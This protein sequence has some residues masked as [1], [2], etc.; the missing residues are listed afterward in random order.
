MD[1]KKSLLLLALFMC[2]FC[3]LTVAMIIGPAGTI[4]LSHASVKSSSNVGPKIKHFIRTPLNRTLEPCKK[5]PNNLKFVNSLEE[6]RGNISTVFNLNNSLAVYKSHV[7]PEKMMFRQSF[8]TTG[9]KPT[10]INGDSFEDN[11]YTIETQ[12]SCALVGSSGILNGSHCG[13]EIDSHDFVMRIN[14]PVVAG[15]EKEVGHKTNLTAINSSVFYFL[16]KYLEEK[17][18]KIEKYRHYLDSLRYLA[19]CIIWMNHD[20]SKRPFRMS[21]KQLQTA[22]IKTMVDA[23]CSYRVAYSPVPTYPKLTNRFW[24]KTTASEGFVMFTIAPL[25]CKEITLYG[26]WPFPYDRHGTYVNHHYYHESFY[27]RRNIT[28]TGEFD[29]LQDLNKR[30]VIKLVTDKCA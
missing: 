25:F 24:N 26:F 9:Q 27:K 13:R 1:M 29:I 21:I 23:N 16:R 3:L 10:G 2:A 28:M 18:E 14:L 30:G 5:C 20:I 8:M 17:G 6:L 7:V 19:N 4:F 15:Y 22:L 11:F 12:K